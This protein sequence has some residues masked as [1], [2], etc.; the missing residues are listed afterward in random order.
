MRVNAPAGCIG[1]AESAAPY[2]GVIK[3]L[4]HIFKYG[5]KISLSG[6]LSSLLVD[7]CSESVDMLSFDAVIPVPLPWWRGIERGFNQ[8]EELA[9]PLVREWD[10]ELLTG[11]LL[12][13]RASTPQSTLSRLER[14]M[15][16]QGAFRVK[17]PG[18]IAGANILLVDDVITTG[19]TLNECAKVLKE[20]GAASVGAVTL[21]KGS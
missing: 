3:E 11:H 10:M 8:A 20:A 15:N 16:V 19:S 6:Y 14:L 7:F 2:E 9:R 18:G 21:A 17:H 1:I 5:K 13:N 4:I 12:R